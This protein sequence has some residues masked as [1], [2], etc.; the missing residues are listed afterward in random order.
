MLSLLS[1]T[2]RSTVTSSFG[3]V[4]R[5]TVKVAGVADG[6]RLVFWWIKEMRRDD[7][8]SSEHRFVQI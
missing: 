8:V 7:L 1:P 5:L 6:L 2:V 4:A 3:S